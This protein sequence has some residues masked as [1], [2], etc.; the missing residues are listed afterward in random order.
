[1]MIETGVG[2]GADTEN[3]GYDETAIGPAKKTDRPT[4]GIRAKP[5]PK[6]DYVTENNCIT[7]RR[8]SRLRGS[9]G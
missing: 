5:D 7:G 8:V 1:M 3:G 4:K 6:P 2:T 9:R